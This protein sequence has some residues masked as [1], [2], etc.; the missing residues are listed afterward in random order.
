MMICYMDYTWKH[1]L[2]QTTKEEVRR[3]PVFRLKSRVALKP[4]CIK[5]F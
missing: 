3:V 5:L 2:H 4:T 1:E